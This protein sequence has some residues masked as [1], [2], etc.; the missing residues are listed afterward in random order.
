M[1]RPLT[2]NT[3]PCKSYFSPKRNQLWRFPR[4]LWFLHTLL[5]LRHRAAGWRHKWRFVPRK[6]VPVWF[7]T[8]RRKIICK[9]IFGKKSWLNL[10]ERM[11][12]Q[13]SKGNV[14]LFDFCFFLIFLQDL[15]SKWLQTNSLDNLFKNFLLYLNR[16]YL[17]LK[18][19]LVFKY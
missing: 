3:F 9:T 10:V 7:R 16:G 14:C 18:F 17:K 19:T 11:V 15:A 4:Q 6:S 8:E 2:Q 12:F 13:N 1:T 5:W